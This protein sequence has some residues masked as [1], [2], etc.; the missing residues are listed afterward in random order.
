MTDLT[1]T[2]GVSQTTADYVRSTMTVRRKIFVISN[3]TKMV[4]TVL[5]G[6]PL[7]L[8]VSAAVLAGGK[9]D[10]ELAGIMAVLCGLPTLLAW[11]LPAP[12]S[13]RSYKV[14]RSTP[15]GG[16]AAPASG[17][18][19]EAESDPSDYRNIDAPGALW[20]NP[21]WSTLRGNLWSMDD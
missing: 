1:K 6:V 16:S 13:N 4:V 17:P 14:V 19:A 12:Y 18:S 15:E 5:F 11:R 9:S 3:S 10:L 7:L 21:R 20:L 8:I 2:P